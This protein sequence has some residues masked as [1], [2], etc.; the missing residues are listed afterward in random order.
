MRFSANGDYLVSGG[1]G[2]VRV[3]RVEDGQRMAT[4]P[5][6]SSTVYPLAVSNDGRSIAAGT[7]MGEVYVWDAK[8]YEELFKYR[9]D[10]NSVT[11]V[12]FSPD[13]TRLV[14]GSTNGKVIIWDVATWRQVQTL[15]PGAVWAT[16]YSPQGD[17]IAIARGGGSVH[18]YDSDDGRLLVNIQVAVTPYYNSGLLWFN[19]HLLAISDNKIK[20]FDTS[21]GSAVSEWSVPEN[22]IQSCISQPKHGEF[23]AYSTLNTVTFWNTSTHTQ[24]GVIQRAQDI[25]SIAVSRDDRFIAIGGVGKK[26]IIESLSRI[27]VSAL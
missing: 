11:G 22:N 23:V 19:N 17:R 3:W 26:I 27:N 16:K 6:G 20:E 21:T 4:I 25:Y 15:R 8:T 14:S 9:K 2:G 1:N 12:D 18:V 13:S 10:T 24:L 7:I 5:T